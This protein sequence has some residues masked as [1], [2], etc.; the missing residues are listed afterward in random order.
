MKT[1][2]STKSSEA[3]SDLT[4][5]LKTRKGNA[6]DLAHLLITVLRGWEI[7]ARFVRGYQDGGEADGELE[8]GF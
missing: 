8:V 4:E 3:A 6:D 5:V 1:S 7:P 2:S